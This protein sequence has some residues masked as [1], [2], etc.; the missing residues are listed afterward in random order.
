MRL[1]VTIKYLSTR[2]VDRAT[3][4][5]LPNRLAER[6]GSFV[7][8]DW[9]VSGYA[10]FSSNLLNP[11]FTSVEPKTA[12]CKLWSNFNAITAAVI[13]REKHT[14]SNS[15][16][17]KIELATNALPKMKINSPCWTFL[18]D[19]RAL[20]IFRWDELKRRFNSKTPRTKLATRT[21]ATTAVTSAVDRLKR[22]RVSFNHRISR[23][24]LKIRIYYSGIR[25]STS[26]GINIDYA[27]LKLKEINLKCITD[28]WRN[29]ASEVFSLLI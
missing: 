25:R 10:R 27:T 22:S 28:C 8:V 3:W 19:L 11:I 15:S 20:F 7:Y 21:E 18:F 26:G 23:R 1:C 5:K 24:G 14:S 4:Q 9:T 13:K 6:V 12:K 17:F 29:S 16:N 2:L